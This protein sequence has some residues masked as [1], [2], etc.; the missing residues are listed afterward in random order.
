MSKYQ[1]SFTAYI[2]GLEASAV[3]ECQAAAVAD[4]H[5]PEDSE[6]CENGELGCSGCPWREGA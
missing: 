5:S 3:M 2:E 6:N 4:G 1:A